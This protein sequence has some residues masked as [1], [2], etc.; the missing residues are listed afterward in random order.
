[1]EIW[2]I[3]LDLSSSE[4]LLQSPFPLLGLYT[5]ERERKYGLE[6]TVPGGKR[7]KPQSQMT[8]GTVREGTVS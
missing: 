5:T 4:I 2:S 7:K 1:M 3:I 6:M 8:W